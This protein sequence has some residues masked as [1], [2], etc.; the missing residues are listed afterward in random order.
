MPA[1]LKVHLIF[2][3]SMLKPFHEDQG[4]P[5]RGESQQASIGVKISFDKNIESIIADRVVR[6]KNYMPRHEYLVQWK[7]LPNSEASWELAEA[8]WQF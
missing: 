8:L 1:K 2:H 6:R 7:E 5:A 4:D 3:V